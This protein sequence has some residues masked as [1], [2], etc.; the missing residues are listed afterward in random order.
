MPYDGTGQFTLVP[1][2]PV[3]TGTIIS[4]TWANS[5]LEDIANNGLSN[6]MTKDG[7]TEPI[8]NIPMNGFRLTNLGLAT[9][10]G[11]G[12]PAGQVQSGGL[13]WLTNVSGTE[14]ITATAQPDFTAYVAGQT[15]RFASVGANATTAVTLNVNGA[16][17]KPVTKSGDSPLAPGDIANGAAVTV[18]YDGTRFQ[19]ENTASAGLPLNYR[20]GGKISVGVQAATIQ[21]G[22]WRDTANT[23]DLVL[24]TALTKN[25]QASGA[26]A[27]GNNANGLFTGAVV[28]NTWYHIF[29]I[30]NDT[31]GAIDAGFDTSLIAAN[32]PSG[33]TAFR[34][35]GSVLTNASAQITPM[36]NTGNEFR[37]AV[38]VSNLDAF[39]LQDHVRHLLVMTVPPGLVVRVR[40]STIFAGS[41]GVD[42]QVSVYC[43]DESDARI[44]GNAG[45]GPLGRA[46]SVVAW[47][48]TDES[49]FRAGELLITTNTARQI[50]F[51]NTQQLVASGIPALC[52]GTL[53]WFD[54]IG[55]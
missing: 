51:I 19:L 20:S 46:A 17:A 40:M 53:G 4:S 10:A 21:P 25:L 37:W 38:P 2:N 13:L 8:A 42:M 5:T 3:V 39:A 33:W 6:A 23:V 34:R 27:A 55:E 35:V 15:F 1:G 7:Q 48:R 31:T 50:A 26:W 52:F 30:R 22:A 32:I 43:P 29:V 18:T 12:V 14:T 28:I 54:F 24:R 49:S 11:D 36:L 44:A 41:D 45:T 47:G 16:G 9:A